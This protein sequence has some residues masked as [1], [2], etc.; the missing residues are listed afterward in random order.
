MTQIDPSRWPDYNAAQRTRA[1]R[2]LA[3]TAAELAGPASGR[4]A[5]ELGCGIGREATFLADL[6]WQVR[7]FDADPSVSAHLTG[8]GIHHVEARLED[9]DDLPD[10]GLLLA[11]AALPFVPRD[12][13]PRLWDA[14]LRALQPGG[15]LAVD[16]FGDRD[17]WA[18]GVG[19]F[20]ARHEV[21]S[22]VAE[23]EVVELHEEEV[24]SMAFS[25]PKHWHTY[26]LLA[27]KP[28]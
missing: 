5:V 15:V 21:R 10:C 16:L 6:G 11:C 12:R 1:V 2:P 4:T 28:Q 23:L 8:R 27:Q 3:R 9:L 17:G 13:F 19:T 18:H 7:T 24:D 26:R 20:L 22:L 14:C 25:G